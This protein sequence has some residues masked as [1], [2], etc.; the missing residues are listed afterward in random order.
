[1]GYVSPYVTEPEW[2]AKCVAQ[3][4]TLCNLNCTSELA[5]G[6]QTRRSAPIALKSGVKYDI[7]VTH[8]HTTSTPEAF[9][10]LWQSARV[11]LAP[12]AGDYLVAQSTPQIAGTGFNTVYYNNN[13][14]NGVITPDLANPA[15]SRHEPVFD[16]ASS[17]GGPSQFP[18]GANMPLV[19]SPLD[20]MAPP[21]SVVS[22]PDGS[23]LHDL[24]VHVTGYGV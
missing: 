17:G 24:T 2:D 3:V 7:V 21:P 9:Q 1:G 23:T 5:A 4:K 12:I 13:D 6:R 16:V 15:T 11:P 10:L 22:P 19:T 18:R 14:N 20:W 8:H